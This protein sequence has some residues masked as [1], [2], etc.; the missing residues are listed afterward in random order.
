MTPTT[1]FEAYLQ[2]S[3]SRRVGH[4]WQCPGHRDAS[5]SLSLTE[6]ME[7]RVLV[8][9][10]A[11]CP[12]D[13]IVD[14]LGLSMSALFE[15]P[16][17]APER[18]W[19][20]SRAQ[21]LYPELEAGGSGGRGPRLGV[22]I[23]TGFHYYTDDARLRRERFAGG[24]KRITWEERIGRT[25]W[26][27]GLSSITLAELPLYRQVEALQGALC[28]EEVIVC[29]SESSVDALFDAG[30]YATTWAGGATSPNLDRLQTVLSDHRVLLV[31]DNDIPGLD[32]SRRIREALIDKTASFRELLPA[33]GE[34]ARDIL[35]TAGTEAFRNQS[36]APAL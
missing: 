28:G 34:D 3:G 6:G 9:C 30:L 22:P 25:T 2:R 17:F 32:C 26:S 12:T 10:F 24:K 23:E 4:M 33:A 29:E 11:G 18:A 1:W 27:G 7:G 35:R 14:V 21:V 8:K 19:R 20:D 5:P 16:P 36:F 13:R 15:S 31:P